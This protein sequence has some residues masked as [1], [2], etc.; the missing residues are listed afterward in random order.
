MNLHIR[1]LKKQR[2][3]TC[4]CLFSIMLFF[5]NSFTFLY[6]LITDNVFSENIEQCGLLEKESESEPSDPTIQEEEQHSFLLTI[7]SLILH[8]QMERTYSRPALNWENIQQKTSIPPPK[9]G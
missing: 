3:Y 2:I 7:S 4:V 1:Q 6:G 8:K 9:L 5:T